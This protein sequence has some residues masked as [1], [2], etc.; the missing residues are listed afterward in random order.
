M[1]EYSSLCPSWR[2][3]PRPSGAFLSGILKRT[4]RRGPH[5][6]HRTLLVSCPLD[7]GRRFLRYF[8]SFFVNFVFFK[9]L[10]SN[11]LERSQPHFKGN[12]SDF[13][14]ALAKPI[15]NRLRKVQSGCRC[16]DG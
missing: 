14:S 8:V 12:L 4:Y 15:E 1:Q 11:R 3:H 7:R 2:D 9:N 13:T 5:S 6:E 10:G 16:G